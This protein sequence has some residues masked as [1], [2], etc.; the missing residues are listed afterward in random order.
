MS[1]VTLSRI[2][3]NIH[4]HTAT[5]IGALAWTPLKYESE[6]N[7]DI[8]ELTTDGIYSSSC[9]GGTLPPAFGDR[10]GQ[11]MVLDYNR[12]WTVQIIRS[13]H[14]YGFWARKRYGNS[15]W[16]DWVHI[17]DGGEAASVKAGGVADSIDAIR[18]VWISSSNEPNKRV[19]SSLTF[20]EDT[21]MLTTN[22]SGTAASARN[23]SSGTSAP[24]SL[25]NGNIYLVY[26]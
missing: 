19:T 3:E 14:F 5:E 18:S 25:A 23:I 7:I 21:D 13:P 6:P 20:R 4:A 26:S 9:L 15:N 2:N 11:I 24:S 22:I 12:F 16:M 17:A 8:D 10:Q 1:S